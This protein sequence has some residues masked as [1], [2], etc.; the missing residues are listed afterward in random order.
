MSHF[1]PFVALAVAT[2]VLGVW[3][4]SPAG[5]GSPASLGSVADCDTTTGEWVITYTFST[6]NNFA[7][8]VLDATWVLS[9]GSEGTLTFA[10]TTVS[11]DNP[12]T[13]VLR[14]PGASTGTLTGSAA[15]RN[16]GDDSVDDILDGSC[17]A[18]VTTTTSTTSTTTA[19]T[20][21]TAAPATDEV[22]AAVPTY[23]G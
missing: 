11:Q 23:T 15:V 10:P 2:A 17:A 8:D 18:V 6:G 16:F 21:T 13:A 7:E 20:T 4:I 5:A 19:P 3:S 9:S 22:V 1:R 14:L 12:S